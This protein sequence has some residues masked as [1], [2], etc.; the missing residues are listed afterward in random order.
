M[1]VFT[2]R[3][4]ILGET[5]PSVAVAAKSLGMAHLQRQEIEQAKAYFF[6]A[7]NVFALGGLGDHPMANQ[8]RDD[9]RTLGFDLDRVEI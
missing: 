1:E 3:K 2:M 5:H 8:L 4:A 7:L 9:I 6:Q